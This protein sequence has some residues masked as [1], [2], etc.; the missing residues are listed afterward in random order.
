[1]R[2]LVATVIIVFVFRCIFSVVRILEL[3]TQVVLGQYKVRYLETYQLENEDT[4]LQFTNGAA[5]NQDHHSLNHQHRN[6]KAEICHNS[7]CSVRRQ[8][9]HK[10]ENGGDCNPHWIVKL[11]QLEYFRHEIRIE[12][13]LHQ[14][15]S[16]YLR[17]YVI[18]K[19]KTYS[20]LCYF[21]K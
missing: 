10:E 16:A 7:N 13:N 11:K 15:H 2:N 17:F 18:P 5:C 12:V 20:Y 3:Q 21:L 9:P 1:M 4:I 19:G 14:G 6:V 8:L